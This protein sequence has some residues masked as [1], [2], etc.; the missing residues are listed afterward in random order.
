MMTTSQGSTFDD[1][2]EIVTTAPIEIAHQ[3]TGSSMTSSMPRGAG[4][5]FQCAVVVMG[6]VGAALN[7]LILYAMVAS[8]QHNK[9]VLIFNQ[10]L[11]DFV[12]CFFLF[13]KNTISLF[14]VDLSGTRGYWLCMIVFSEALLLGPFLGSLI[15]L[16]AITIERYLKVVHHVW[17]KKNLRKWMIYSV[18]PFAWIG[19]NAVAWGWTIPTTDV[20]DGV[21]YTLVLWKSRSARMAFSI[22]HFLTFY[23]GLFLTFIFCY[24]RIL[25]VVR[26]QASVMASHGTQGGSSAAETQIT[27]MQS[28]VIKTMILVSVLY[29]VLWTPGFVHFVLMNISV[30]F[31]V[32]DVAFYVV[33]IIGFLYNCVN[34]F[35]YATNFDPV[36]HVLLR[37][38][39]WKKNTQPLGNVE[40][41]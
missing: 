17:A 18:I 19:G 22:W 25:M 7:G 8:K 39:P 27:K 12:S 23:V 32:G 6:F 40:M 37:M 4:F 2:T 5:Y 29:I 14:G 9:R 33:Q 3:T 41:I 10:N 13:A 38:I 36:M 24:G 11:L 26:R 21:C 35:I 15:N 16:A 34:P 20:I 1:P 28:N 30:T 31:E